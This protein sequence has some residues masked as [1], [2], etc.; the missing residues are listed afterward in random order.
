MYKTKSNI[1]VKY[2]YYILL[3]LFSGHQLH[4]QI[5]DDDL[6]LYYP[7]NGN[8][9]D[10]SG[11]GFHGV[12]N[13]TLVNDRAGNE[14]SAYYFNGMT[15][16]IEIPNE[17]DLKTDFP[18]AISLWFRVEEFNE[19]TRVLFTNDEDMDGNVYSG[20]WLLYNSSGRVSAG[21]G[22]AISQS[23]AGRVT[24]H[25]NQLINAGEWYHVVASF[26]ALNDIDLYINCELDEGY[27]SG[28][29]N[30]MVYLNSTGAVGRD[31]GQHFSVSNHKGEIDDVRF[32]STSLVE[33]DVLELCEETTTASVFDIENEYNFI[34][35]YPNPTNGILNIRLATDLKDTKI[36]D[37]RLINSLGEIILTKKIIKNTT[38]INLEKRINKGFYFLQMLD[39][40]AK[41]LVN[42]KLIFN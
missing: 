7:F 4:A 1:M 36:S 25:A 26:N 14:E 37:V 21:Y 42:K 32:F 5:S 22:N 3:F 31:L 20:F 33:E 38:Q 17:N 27:Y 30:S 41:I 11:H 2:I 28:S 23:P 13:A 9:N 6:L 18:F 35:I 16:Y 15:S 10:E 8:S 19:G 24:K 12:S 39:S 29:A 34:T 40:D